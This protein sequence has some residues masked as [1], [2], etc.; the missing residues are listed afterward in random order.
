MALS[1][2]CFPVPFSKRQWSTAAC[3]RP[4]EVQTV[5]RR[6]YVS[7]NYL[8][9][10]LPDVYLVRM[11]EHFASLNSPSLA[12]PRLDRP[13]QPLRDGRRIVTEGVPSK[14]I[15]DLHRLPWR[16]IGQ[17]QTGHSHPARPGRQLRQRPARRLALRRTNGN[18]AV[19]RLRRR[20]VRLSANASNARPL[21]STPAAAPSS[22]EAD[23]APIRENDT[24]S[25]IIIVVRYCRRCSSD[26]TCGTGTAFC[27]IRRDCENS[28]CAFAKSPTA[29]FKD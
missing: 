4:V 7:I 6:K 9:A 1:G 11:A 2:P 5:R 15:R 22:L 24:S 18:R 3:Q 19:R 21:K 27:Q 14:K 20:I 13:A 29:H 8:L 12:Q 26:S 25:S 16:R 28:I 10:Y 17:A 23:I